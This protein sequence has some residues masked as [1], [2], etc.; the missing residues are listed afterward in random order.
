M[1]GVR[2]MRTADEDSE[3]WELLPFRTRPSAEDGK[4]VA[5]V[6]VTR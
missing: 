6:E 1:G 4:T 5:V 2:V 3:N